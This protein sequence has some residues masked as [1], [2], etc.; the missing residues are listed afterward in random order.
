MLFISILI[1]LLFTLLIGFIASRW[2]KNSQDFAL[3]GRRLSLVVSGTSLFATWFGSE[4]ILGA[5]AE[6][7]EKGLMGIIEEPLGAVL[8]LIFI[9]L[10]FA[11][12]IYRSNVLTFG[13]FFKIKYGKASELIS[14]LIM[15]FTY[16]GWIAAQLV[17]LGI[18]LNIASDDQLSVFAGTCIGAFIV[19]LYTFLGGMWAVSITDLIQ[20]FII[21]TGLLLVFIFITESAGGLQAVLQSTPPNQF[22]FFPKATFRD[23]LFY[24][25]AWLTIG[26]GGIPS[27]DVFQ[28]V[29]SA[30]SERVAVW[31]CYLAAII[32][33]SVVLLPL[34]IAL[35]AK[36]LYPELMLGDL[37]MLLPKAVL[38]S[39]PPLLQILFFGA[40]VSAIMSTA[41]G[42]ILAPASL[43]AENILKPLFK[44]QSDKSL[45]FLLRFSVVL[46]TILSFFL[47][48]SNRSI[49]E[50]SS[51]TFSSTL[52]ALF[53]PITA[54]IYFKNFSHTGAILS[55]FAGLSS[56]IFVKIMDYQVIPE[57]FVGLLFSLMGMLTGNLSE[58]L[59]G[60]FSWLK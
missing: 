38:L 13:D 19:L 57:I 11:A 54:A 25:A 24:L 51:L 30:K 50:L 42:A 46:I 12:P 56:W 9:G 35:A 18:V 6:F 26:W 31:T 41:S 28:R 7:V 47:A 16:F 44:T 40:L 14:S 43:L 21:I 27:Q 34:F 37:Q 4:T 32:Y 48:N 22:Q 36:K 33:L 1:Y 5:S 58:R 8:S 3:A 17:A 59:F 55:M 52:V 2:V 39:T 15:V 45:L 29:M 20:S 49:F 60:K 53:V 10:F 23:I